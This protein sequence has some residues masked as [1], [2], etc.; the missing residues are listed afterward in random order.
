[1]SKKTKWTKE[2]VTE[3]AKKYTNRSVFHKN[4]QS[5]YQAAR[6]LNILDEVCAHMTIEKRGRKA[7]KEV[8]QENVQAVEVTTTETDSNTQSEEITVC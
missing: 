5:A 7:K 4:E 8:K 2:T 1:M 3:V 6:R